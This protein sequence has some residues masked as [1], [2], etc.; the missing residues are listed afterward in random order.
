M[1]YSAICEAILADPCYQGNLDWGKA[2]HGHPEG[3]VR[4]HIAD[5]ER[6]D[7]LRKE[8]D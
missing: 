1:D 7:V 8:V 6:I 2:R 3:T 4:A 5:L